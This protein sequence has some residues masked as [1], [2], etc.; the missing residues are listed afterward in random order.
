[1]QR[2]TH[3]S[4]YP[5]HHTM[6]NSDSHIVHVRRLISSHPLKANL[7][8]WIPPHCQRQCCHFNAASE[9]ARGGGS[10]F[11][12]QRDSQLTHHKPVAVVPGIESKIHQ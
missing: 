7:C 1:M 3:Q 8:T 4:Q 2:L 6:N 9:R 10:E 5:S 11:R 12:K